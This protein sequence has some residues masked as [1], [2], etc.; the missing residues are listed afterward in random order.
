MQHAPRENRCG[1]C[2]QPMSAWLEVCAPN[3]GVGPF[4]LCIR[5][6]PSLLSQMFAGFEPR[7]VVV[8]ACTP[9]AGLLLTGPDDEPEQHDVELTAP[10]T[11]RG[12]DVLAAAFEVDRAMVSQDAAIVATWSAAADDLLA[13][14]ARR[15]GWG[16]GYTA[17]YLASVQRTLR[18]ELP[19]L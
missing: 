17:D 15:R 10:L 14:L 12:R 2:V 11:R 3:E 9:H 19:G 13:L 7:A 8:R 4:D 1:V 18:G 6:A 16:P 5:C